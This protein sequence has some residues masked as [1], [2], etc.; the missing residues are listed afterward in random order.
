MLVLVRHADRDGQ[1]D[2]LTEDGRA[3]ARELAHVGVNAGLVA[4]Y[5]SDTNRARDTAEPLATAAGLTPV[6]YPASDI[7]SLVAT[8]FADHRGKKVLIVGH[9]N[10]IPDII[11]AVGGPVIPDIDDKEFDNLFVLTVCRCGRKRA[12]LL[13]LQYGAASPSRASSTFRK[14][15]SI[16]PTSLRQRFFGSWR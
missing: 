9:S 8:I 3:R 16:N 10:T 15:I 5:R 11:E 6:V 2:A 13:T 12:T 1:L 4:I 14:E 7:E